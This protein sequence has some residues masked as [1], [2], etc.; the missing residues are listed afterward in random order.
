MNYASKKTII[1]LL[2]IFSLL[3]MVWQENA[4][5]N[6]REGLAPRQN[7]AEFICGIE[8]RDPESVTG[9]DMFIRFH[10]P[11]E[12][13]VML[14]NFL[15]INDQRGVE[16]PELSDHYLNVLIPP[17]RH[18]EIDCRYINDL[19]FAAADKTPEDARS[20]KVYMWSKSIRYLE[21]AMEYSSQTKY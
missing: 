15:K 17:N 21:I 20:F 2:L 13:P 6:L 8:N 11:H 3:S 7:I 12:F 4:E 18:F 9:Y 10:N 5:A 1:I 19:F 14:N 16:V